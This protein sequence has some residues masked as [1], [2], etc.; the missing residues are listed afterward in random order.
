MSDGSDA[1][2][3]TFTVAARPSEDVADSG[4]EQTAADPSYCPGCGRPTSADG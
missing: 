3:R 1:V 4:L 2:A